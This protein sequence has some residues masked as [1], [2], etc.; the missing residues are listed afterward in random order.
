M[1]FCSF[2]IDDCFLSM[3]IIW[4]LYSSKLEKK[5]GSLLR[6]YISLQWHSLGD[7]M[8]TLYQNRLAWGQHRF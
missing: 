4:L 3:I 7:K 6:E 2:S 1:E 5:T 8:E